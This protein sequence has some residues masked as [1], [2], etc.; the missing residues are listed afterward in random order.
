MVSLSENFPIEMYNPDVYATSGSFKLL[1]FIADM[2]NYDCKYC[3]NVKPRTGLMLDLAVLRQFVVD[4]LIGQ[5]HRDA[6]HIELIGGEP[7]LHPDLPVF[8]SDMAAVEN[9][10]ITIFS[11]F[12]KPAEYY[13][14]LLDS[15]SRVKLILSWHSANGQSSDFIDKLDG[16]S[17]DQLRNRITV[18]VI[19]EH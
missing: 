10:Y 19:Y 1:A 9:A 18:S 7:T 4:I 16:F 12:S 13:R 17:E 8:C 6:I 5:I 14:A 2:C 15:N 3:Y 11:N